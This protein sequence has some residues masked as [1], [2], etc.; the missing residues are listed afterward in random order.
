MGSPP[1]TASER[2]RSYM[3]IF[4]TSDRNWVGIQVCR[5]LLSEGADTDLT[6]NLVEVYNLN[7]NIEETDSVDNAVHKYN[8]LAS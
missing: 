8:P 7:I 4:Q 2:T 5:G 3:V 1:Q 6:M